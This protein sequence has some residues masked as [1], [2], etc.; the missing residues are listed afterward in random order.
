MPP[1]THSMKYVKSYILEIMYV[2]EMP[3]YFRQNTPWPILSITDDKA[4]QD[5]KNNSQGHSQV[6]L[7]DILT[8]CL[9]LPWKIVEQMH[10]NL[11]SIIIF[12]F[13]IFHKETIQNVNNVILTIYP[14]YW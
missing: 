9:C 3:I 14:P 2:T 10:D 13:H 11:E 5:H 7:T 6:F 8:K 1:E 12:V 4:Q